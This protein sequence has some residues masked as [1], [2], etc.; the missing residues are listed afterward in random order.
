[1]RV[2]FFTGVKIKASIF[3]IREKHEEAWR[4]QAGTFVIED[5]KGGGAYKVE[6]QLLGDDWYDISD[7]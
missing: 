2:V 6:I 1:M 7:T 3:G 5:D 4:G